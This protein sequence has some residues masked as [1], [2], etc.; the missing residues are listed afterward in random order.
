MPLKV[1]LLFGTRPEV[2]KLAPVIRILRANPDKFECR[3]CT[4]GQHRQMADQAMREFSLSPDVRLD[5]MADG[6]SLAQLTGRLFADIDQLLGQESP[7]WL[8]VQGDTTSAMVAAMCAFYRQIKVGHVEAGLRTGDRWAPF[9]EEINRT[10]IGDVAD[11]HFAP[12]SRAADNLRAAGAAESSIHVTGNTVVDALLW[13]TENMGDAIP[14]SLD[15]VLVDSIRARRLILVTSHRRESFG[16][17]L[18]NICRALK[19][20][21][22]GH[23]DVAIVY[24]VHLNPNV[25]GPVLKLLGGESRIHLIEPVGYGAFVYLM[26]KSYFILTDSGGIQE[27][28]PALGKPILIMRDVTERPEVIESGC[29]RLVGT[30]VNNIADAASELLENRSAY[31]KMANRKD[32]FGDGRAAERIVNLLTTE[33]HR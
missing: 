9:P 28:A 1:L 27:E 15:Q 23:P 10:I 13:T 30:D 12:T 19:E 3:V 5:A 26:K 21:V 8:L 25:R 20:I 7:D 14:A 22:C 29:G 24:P 4:T 11:L 2:I 17:G 16:Q 31:E 18:E 6:R 32:P 33:L